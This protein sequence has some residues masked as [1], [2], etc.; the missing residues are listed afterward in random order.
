MHSE[1]VTALQTTANKSNRKQQLGSILNRTIEVEHCE[2]RNAPHF[3]DHQQGF[4]KYD[5][6]RH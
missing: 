5:M 3:I 1:T 2:S 4:N 6:E